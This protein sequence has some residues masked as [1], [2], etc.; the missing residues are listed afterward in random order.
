M[1][2]SNEKINITIEKTEAGYVIYDDTQ[3]FMD[4]VHIDDKELVSNIVDS[5]VKD[6]LNGNLASSIW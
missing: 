3:S 5:I 1:N 4:V 6:R 2:T